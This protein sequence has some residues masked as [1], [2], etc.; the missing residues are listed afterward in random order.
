MMDT[1]D[2][3]WFIDFDKCEKRAPGQWTQA[4]LERLRRSLRKTANEN[5]ALHW[6]EEDWDELLSGY[7]D[8]A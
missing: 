3:V 4:N 2:K 8:T 7:T 1:R 6:R 5:P